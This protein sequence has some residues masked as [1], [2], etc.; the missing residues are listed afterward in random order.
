LLCYIADPR[1]PRAQ[2]LARPWLR[3]CGIISYE[4]YLFHQPIIFWART[5]FG[6]AGG[7][8]LKYGLVAGG[9]FV[10]GLAVAILVYRCFSL[11]ILRRGRARHPSEFPKS[12]AVRA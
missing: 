6:P 9:S 2:L 3:W 7:N 1:H 10:V 11:P 5:S 4:W 12:A 8:V